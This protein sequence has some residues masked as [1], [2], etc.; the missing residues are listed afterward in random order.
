MVLTQL[1][2]IRITGNSV[3][4]TIHV[5]GQLAYKIT[6]RSKLESRSTISEI[7]NAR[8]LFCPYELRIV[9]QPFHLCNIEE[10]VIPACGVVVLTLANR[11]YECLECTRLAIALYCMK[12]QNM[13]RLVKTVD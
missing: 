9:I 5:C 10:D 12:Y 1:R 4:N 8:V 11:S 6:M 7:R 13:K 3:E 2:D